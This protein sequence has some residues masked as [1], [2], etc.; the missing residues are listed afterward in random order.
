MH[1]GGWIPAQQ[2]SPH[3][4]PVA[5]WLGHDL[6]PSPTGCVS[7][8][9]E[10]GAN[11]T[12]P[13]PCQEHQSELA[14]CTGCCLFKALGP[15]QFSQLFPLPLA[16][17]QRRTGLGLFG[18]LPPRSRTPASERLGWGAAGAG[19]RLHFQG[20]EGEALQ[21]LWKEGVKKKKKG[22]MESTS[23]HG[24]LLAA[25]INCGHP[26]LSLPLCR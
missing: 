8:V 4:G 25:G 10:Q 3:P 6:D 21:C 2:G 24:F 26:F 1:A 15:S 7:A 17:P 14:K 16:W 11:K 19:A 9:R 18:Q 12:A 5:A 13:R 22:E 23:K 20:Q